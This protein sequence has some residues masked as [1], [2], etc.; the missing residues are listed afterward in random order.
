MPLDQVDKSDARNQSW[1]PARLHADVVPHATNDLPFVT[2]G[3]YVGVGGDVEIMIADGKG[4]GAVVIYVGAAA[5]SII[6]IAAKRVLAANT[7]ATNLV[8]MG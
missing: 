2:R 8:A 5:G 3:I 6:P 7:T 1:A 4:D